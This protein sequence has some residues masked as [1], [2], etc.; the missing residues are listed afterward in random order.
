MLKHADHICHYYD[1][2]LMRSLMFIYYEIEG[3]SDRLDNLPKQCAS[4]G[5]NN[6]SDNNK[7][8]GVSLILLLLS[9]ARVPSSTCIARNFNLLILL[10]TDSMYLQSRNRISPLATKP[11]LNCSLAWQPLHQSGCKPCISC[12]SRRVNPSWSGPQ[13]WVSRNLLWDI[14]R[15][16]LTESWI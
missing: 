1:L 2:Q 11:S 10:S 8:C 16:Q 14:D 3:K 5:S 9:T 13:C 4:T 6:T 12:W 7:I 15:K